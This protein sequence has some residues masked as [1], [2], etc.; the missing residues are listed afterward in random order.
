MNFSDGKLSIE[1]EDLDFSNK[2]KE[3]LP[4]YYEGETMSIGFNAKF[5]IEMLNTIDGDN[6]KIELTSPKHAG[7][8][9]PEESELGEDLLMLIMPVMIN[10]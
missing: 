4:C 3:Q 1:A 10:A 2:A 8:I 9:R 7:V 5:M 6:V